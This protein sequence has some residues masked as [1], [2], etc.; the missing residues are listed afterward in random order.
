MQTNRLE[1]LSHYI[2]SLLVC[3]PHETSEQCL[4]QDGVGRECLTQFS[5][6]LF[7]WCPTR[8]HGYGL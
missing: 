4:E 2:S 1:Y 3:S 7:L 8:D 6:Q 5:L